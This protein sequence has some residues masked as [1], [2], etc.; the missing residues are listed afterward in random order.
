MNTT[1]VKSFNLILLTSLYINLSSFQ[2]PKTPNAKI[3]NKT[4]DLTSI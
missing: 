2:V 1:R 4:E 3:D